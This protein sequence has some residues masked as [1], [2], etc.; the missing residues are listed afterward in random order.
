M[1]KRMQQKGTVGLCLAGFIGSNYGMLLQAYATQ[2]VVDKLG[3][4]TEIIKYKSGKNKG[5]K[6]SIGAAYVASKTVASKIKRKIAPRREEMDATHR[7][8]RERRYKIAEEF[9]ERRWHSIVECNGIDELRALSTKYES[10]LVGSDQLW[11]PDIAFTNFYTLRFAAPGVK[12]ISYATSLGVSE[13][14]K[15]CRKQARDYWRKIDYIS[16][17]E[18]Q[19]ADLIEEIAGIRPEVV[20]DPTYLLTKEGWLD[21]IPNRIVYE[22]RYVLCYFLS[23]DKDA[24]TLAIRFAHERGFKCIGILSSECNADDSDLD[25]VLTD[26][27]PEDFINLIRNAECVFTDSFHGLAFS[28]IN[29]KDFYIFYRKRTDVRASRKSR[30]DN[31][32]SKYGLEK[33]LVI[34]PE[35]GLQEIKSI[36]YS[37]IKRK[38]DSIRSESLQFLIHA[39]DG[40]IK[41]E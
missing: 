21:L 35:N 22:E 41:E 38:V 5:I 23:D 37:V 3:Y 33:R 4:K 27:T 40:E 15:Y 13:Y 9:R 1:D 8:N 26:K 16:V 28:V 39:L 17:R 18:E 11:Q 20:A 19:G 2:Q 36:D 7:A 12:R 25:E 30:I 24:K 14:P 29:D 10:V 32:L 34:N 6:P 31:I